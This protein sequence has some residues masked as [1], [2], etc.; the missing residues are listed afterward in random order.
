MHYGWTMFKY[1]L[2]Q[3]LVAMVIDIFGYQDIVTLVTNLLS[4]DIPAATLSTVMSYI[5]QQWRRKHALVA[6]TSISDDYWS[7]SLQ[8]RSSFNADYNNS[9]QIYFQQQVDMLDLY[10][11]ERFSPPIQPANEVT[12]IPIARQSVVSCTLHDSNNLYT[13]VTVKVQL[14]FNCVWVPKID[15]Q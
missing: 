11:Q 12:T 2:L 14:K 15:I 10:L 4:R 7:N 9:M 13:H 6:M 8:I 1:H 3:S 5:T